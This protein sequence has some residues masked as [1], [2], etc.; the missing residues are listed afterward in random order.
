[1][2]FPALRSRRRRARARR[3]GANAH[4]AND[5]LAA[6]QV[7]INAIGLF[8][9][10]A[11]IARRGLLGRI[12]PDSCVFRGTMMVFEVASSSAILAREEG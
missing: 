3:P 7:I 6:T 10:A 11:I 4:T 5:V 8:G 12:D 9:T 2:P 1:M